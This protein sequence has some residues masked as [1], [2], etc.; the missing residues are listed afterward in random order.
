MA[1]FHMRYDKP[2]P[3]V[4]KDEKPQ[5]APLHFWE[6]YTRKFWHLVRLNL[7]YVVFCVLFYLP[8]F[9]AVSVHI[10]GSWLFYLCTLSILFTGPFTAGFVY[11][12]RDFARERPSFIWGDFKDAA[13]KNWKQALAVSA[14]AVV[15]FDCFGI[16]LQLYTV[17]LG[18]QP[19]AC[20][21]LVLLFVC[22]LLFLF[23]Q[24]YVFLILVTFEMKLKDVYHNALIFAF[25][26][27][28]RNILV[29][30][31][32]A[33]I[34]FVTCILLPP[35]LTLLP[36]ITVGTVGLLINFAAWPLV[37]K[38]MIDLHAEHPSGPTA[39]APIFND[40]DKKE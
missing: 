32:S 8:F 22:G 21:L 33:A 29:T 37:K 25:V 6:I 4:S 15:G 17:L 38:Y 40:P 24:Y 19:L 18:K 10:V 23:M 13:R 2:G 1:F 30:V 3:G 5:P 31:L 36:F 39:E 11:E 9:F 27:I 16:L 14:I 7:L 28:G 20:F 35:L 34:L 26:G 12:L